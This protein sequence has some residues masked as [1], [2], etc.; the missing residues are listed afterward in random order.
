MCLIVEACSGAS[1]AIVF[2][3]PQPCCISSNKLIKVVYSAVGREYPI[4]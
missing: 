2:F 3:C 1:W 4:L